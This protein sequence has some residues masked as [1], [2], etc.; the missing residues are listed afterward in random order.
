[1]KRCHR[2]FVSRERGIF[3]FFCL[4]LCSR[5][6]LQHHLPSSFFFPYPLPFYDP[7]KRD[8]EHFARSSPPL[9]PWENEKKKKTAH[10]HVAA[11]N[12]KG[13]ILGNFFFS[14]VE[15]SPLRKD[16]SQPQIGLKNVP[17]LQLPHSITPSPLGPP[18]LLCL[19]DPFGSGGG[20]GGGGE[21]RPRPK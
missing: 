5:S 1:M 3:T 6:N 19:R 21:R 2:P 4:C 11:K 7:S 18:P 14:V 12:E 17:P 15:K 16:K 13:N 8:S 9:P 10:F 20:G